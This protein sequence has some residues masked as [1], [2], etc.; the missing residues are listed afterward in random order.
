MNGIGFVRHFFGKQD[1]F[2]ADRRN[3]PAFCGAIE[4]GLSQLA[5]QV[6][7]STAHGGLIHAEPR[8]CF[9]DVSR[10]DDFDEI[11]EIVPF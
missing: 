10:T 11:T 8:A 7:D 6:S 9:R 1:D 3:D 4:Q 2:F 5:F